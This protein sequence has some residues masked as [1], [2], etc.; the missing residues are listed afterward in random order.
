M[1][2]NGIYGLFDLFLILSFCTY[3]IQT[4][5]NIVIIGGM[6]A[7]C[8]AAARLKRLR[9]DWDVRLIEQKNFISYGSCG[10]PLFAAGELGGFFDLAKTSYGEVRDAA[11]FEN[12]KDVRVMLGTLVSKI[13]RA[14]KVL[15]CQ[16][17]QGRSEVSYDKLL[18]ATGAGPRFPRL[19]LPDSDRISEFHDPSSAVGFRKLAE[20]NALES[21]LILGGGYIGVELA[22]A[23]TSLWGLK[24]YLVEAENRLIPGSTDKDISL[25]LENEMTAAGVEIH[26]S[27]IVQSVEC[28]GSSL[29]AVT[30]RGAGIKADYMF[31]TTGVAPNSALAIDC[32]LD[33]GERGGIVVD[34]H[35][36]TSDPDIFAAGDCVEIFNFA[37]RKRAPMALGSLANRQGRVAADAMAG[38]GTK[39][40]GAAGAVSV[41][42]FETVFAGVGINSV[43][44]QKLGIN[45]ATVEAVFHD[46]PD[47][48]PDVQNLAS[49]I[50]YDRKD[51]RVIGFQAVGKGEASRYSDTIAQLIADGGT[52][53]DLC[54]LEHAYTPAHSSP[55][56]P[57]NIFGYMAENA[58]RDGIYGVHYGSAD[59][60]G[61]TLIDVRTREEF[62][63][64]P[65]IEGAINIPL[66][67]LR[68][69]LK[70]IRTSR[71]V[72]CICERGSR[73]LEAARILKNSLYEAFY[74]AGGLKFM[75]GKL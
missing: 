46:R 42:V 43:A 14:R 20:R 21:V 4:G 36:H 22:E 16:G 52:I 70:E 48:H 63:K 56:S 67:E 9:P 41:K 49:K 10:M 65:G 25:F 2:E 40:G 28:E 19:K 68:G 73:S 26:L 11:Y 13:D 44:A 58:E 60:S 24:A 54:S 71:A 31:V 34:E 47:Y 7:G 38:I 23:V 15:I 39:F 12:T 62:E 37:S 55:L 64:K 29:R 18:I 51:G 45:A 30:A 8:K 72:V 1:P 53:Y 59:F 69:R 61:A 17:P 33:V 66:S 3:R 32:G 50:I 75:S 5:M 27:D 74:L 35:M 57:L 6:A